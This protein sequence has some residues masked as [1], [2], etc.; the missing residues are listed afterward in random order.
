MGALKGGIG[1]SHKEMLATFAEV[2]LIA[3]LEA[4]LDHE[5]LVGFCLAV[6]AVGLLVLEDVIFDQ[7]VATVFLRTVGRLHHIH[8]LTNKLLLLSG[9]EF[10]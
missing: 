3:T 7:A 6:R 10:L 5:A 2:A 9:G 8:D 1:C 4:L